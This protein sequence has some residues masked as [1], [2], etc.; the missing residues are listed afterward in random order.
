MALIHL[1]T[2]YV[3]LNNIA[4]VWLHPLYIFLQPLFANISKGELLWQLTNRY[5][6]LLSIS[7]L[8]PAYLTELRNIIQIGKESAWLK[9]D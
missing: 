6:S 1:R 7:L 3:R 4:G 2:A 5:C 8:G 9:L